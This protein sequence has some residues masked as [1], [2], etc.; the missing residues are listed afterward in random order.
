MSLEDH[1]DA[2]L[3]PYPDTMTPAEV[4]HILR[5]TEA[6]VRKNLTTGDLPGF[7]F[8]RHWII[9]KSELRAF[10]LQSH[11]SKSHKESSSND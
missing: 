5:L 9:G 11:N 6:A 7:K 4:S 1:I 8:S 2:L 3:A 10:L